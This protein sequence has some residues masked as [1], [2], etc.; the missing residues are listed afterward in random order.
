MLIL[1][2]SHVTSYFILVLSDNPVLREKFFDSIPGDIVTFTVYKWL[3]VGIIALYIVPITIYAIFYCRCSFLID[4]IFGTFSFLF[5][6]PTYMNV[7]STFALCRI[8]DISWGTK[9]LDAED[10]KNQSLKETWKTI[11]IIYVAKFIF[12]NTITSIALIV[13]S[14]PLFLNDESEQYDQ[15]S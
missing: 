10:N 11:K 1:V 6:T 8:D 5:Y 12:W 7:L 4:V 14:N 9:G 2:K 13:V 15:E 3:V